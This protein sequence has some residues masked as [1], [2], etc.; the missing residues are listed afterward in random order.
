MIQ[1][2]PREYSR[3]VA[4]YAF[5]F[6]FHIMNVTS[7]VA[8]EEE[9]SLLRAAKNLRLF[10]L[11]LVLLVAF[12][13]AFSMSLIVF[14]QHLRPSTQHV[15]ARVYVILLEEI[16]ALLVLAYVLFR[17]GRSWRDI[18]LAPRWRDLVDTVALTIAAGI[19]SY[20]VAFFLAIYLKD[21]SAVTARNVPHG[22]T[23]IPALLLGFVNP[24]FEELVV[25]AFFMTEL[26]ALT[27]SALIAVLASALFQ[28]SYHIY[29][30][31]FVALSYL[32]LFLIFSFYFARTRRVFPVILAHMFF[33]VTALLYL[34]RC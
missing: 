24:F 19:L 5:I 10:E 16:T 1:A 20:A 32:P 21:A 17:Q 22:L 18:T 4:V 33:D 26:R 14:L 3:G 2:A 8:N 31:A 6:S 23:L 11:C 34:L 12:G 25:R 7:G 29:Q 15:E 13:S 9:K 27:G 30:G 28:T